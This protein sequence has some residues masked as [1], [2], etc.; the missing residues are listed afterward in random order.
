MKPS[1]IMEEHGAWTGLG[2]VLDKKCI[3][4]EEHKKELHELRNII[5]GKLDI[6]IKQKEENQK[7]KQNEKIATRRIKELKKELS[8]IKVLA[9]QIAESSDK[10]M[11]ELLNLIW[12]V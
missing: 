8:E 6:I 4:K 11:D 10:N 7:L 1:E 2:K 3:S 12:R 9:K 5:I